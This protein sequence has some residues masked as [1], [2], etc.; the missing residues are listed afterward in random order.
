VS[1]CYSPRLLSIVLLPGQ[2]EGS[3][4]TWGGWPAVGCDKMRYE[5]SEAA[6]VE[7][8]TVMLM[9]NLTDI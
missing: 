3:R 8:S 6:C 1:P 5:T 2:R 9:V 7:L 4:S